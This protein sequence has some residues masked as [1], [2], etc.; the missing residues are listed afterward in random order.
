MIQLPLK[1]VAPIISVLLFVLPVNAAPITATAEANGWEHDIDTDRPV[2]N[3]SVYDGSLSI[4]VVD[5]GSGV[6][7][8]FVNGYEFTDMED[9]R[10]DIRLETVLPEEG[11]SFVEVLGTVYNIGDNG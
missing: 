5:E 11:F 9:G 6:R 8:I 7:T 1:A 4:E 10:L 2:L 3:A